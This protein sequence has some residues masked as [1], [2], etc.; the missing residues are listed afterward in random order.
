MIEFNE[1]KEKAKSIKTFGL[2]FIQI[3]LSNDTCVNVYLDNINKF[4][5]A[6]APHSHQ[7]SFESTILWGN[8]TEYIYDVK[9][10]H[11]GISAYCG[12]GNVDDPINHRYKY[13]LG[14]MFSYNTGDSYYRNKDDFHSVSAL[15]GTITLIKKD[16][17]DV[18]DAIVISD[19]K[20]SV[21]YDKYDDADLWNMV[22]MTFSNMVV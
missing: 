4:A 2:G 19:S 17:S 5:D 1:L 6:D 8:L 11:D 21:S 20:G 7:R 15:H 9:M 16:I 10:A 12:C 22:E 18:H 3:K 13:V 14:E